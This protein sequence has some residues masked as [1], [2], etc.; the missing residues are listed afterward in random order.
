MVVKE[1]AYHSSTERA[2]CGT[3]H[4]RALLSLSLSLSLSQYPSP[5]LP[6]SLTVLSL[7]LSPSL[8]IPLL[9]SLSLSLSL[10]LP[11]SPVRAANAPHTQSPHLPAPLRVHRGAAKER[12]SVLSVGDPQSRGHGVLAACTRTS[13]QLSINRIR[14]GE[15]L[16]L[17]Q[18]G[19]FV[20][21][22]V[23]DVVPAWIFLEPLSCTL[24]I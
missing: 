22:S 24:H 7:S 18:L 8:N 5:S 9:L 1:W 12:R 11:L 21:F 17:V 10:S 13:A 2:S 20:V 3:V 16:V 23:R 4:C 19:V 14:N 15:L 6:L